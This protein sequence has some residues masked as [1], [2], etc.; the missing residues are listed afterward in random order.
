MS[1]KQPP[2]Q[3]LLTIAELAKRF[4]LP[5]STARY[6]CKRFLAF[7]PHT[8]EGKRR[9]YRNECL[10]VFTRI[11]E[12]MKK[13]KNAMAVEA[14]LAASFPHAAHLSSSTAPATLPAPAAS[15]AAPYTAGTAH[16]G[17]SVDPTMFITLMEQQT[18][19][20]QSI[21]NSLA[22]LQ[23]RVSAL[24]TEE[25]EKRIAGLEQQLEQKDT[26]L[27]SLHKEVA[28]LRTLQEEG[29]KLHQQD[30]EQLRKWLNRIASSQQN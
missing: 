3:P 23:Q 26:A 2:A 16:T 12:E 20:M 11:V 10:A 13:S 29:E 7:L 21:A 17:T 30:F 1:K 22:H 4:S 25:Q 28:A 18:T 19:A 15:E 24:G 8:G 6:Y 9:R 14:A 5:E 27:S